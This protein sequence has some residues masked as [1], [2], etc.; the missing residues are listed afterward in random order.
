MNR[1]LVGKNILYKYNCIENFDF[2]YISFCFFSPDLNQLQ[3]ARGGKRGVNMNPIVL[4]IC[5][6]IHEL[7]AV[8][9]QVF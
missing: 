4:L 8:L 5:V 9:V 7:L 1:L 2:Y 6:C 3:A